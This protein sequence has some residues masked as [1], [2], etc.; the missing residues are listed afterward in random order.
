[1][2]PL[3][4]DVLDRTTLAGVTH[5]PVTETPVGYARALRVDHL[6]LHAQR[7]DENGNVEI[8]GALGQDLLVAA[9]ARTVIVTV[10]E[11]VPRGTL[12]RD[13]RAGEILPRAFVDTVTECPLGAYP[14]SC[15]GY[16]MAD[17]RTL[18]ETVDSE[19][20]GVPEPVAERVRVGRAGHRRGRATYERPPALR[21]PR[22][23]DA[24]RGHDLLPRSGVQR[25]EHLLRR[26]R[27]AACHRV[28][29]A[30]KAHA[31][32]GHDHHHDERRAHRRGTAPGA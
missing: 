24:G 29:S 27:V 20:L 7:A 9:A 14:T 11:I 3:G 16:Y 4:S 32:A 2:L 19:P 8:H 17:Y 28:L 30:R 31:R 1:R 26:C 23:G 10:E 13:R 22:G 5:D 12:Q 15:P 6:L 18:M 21:A 25:R